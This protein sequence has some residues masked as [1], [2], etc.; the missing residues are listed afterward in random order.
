MYILDQ[1]QKHYSK[2][3]SHILSYIYPLER[4]TK[5]PFDMFPT[6]QTKNHKTLLGMSQ[7]F[8]FYCNMD[9]TSYLSISFCLFH[10]QSWFFRGGQSGQCPPGKKKS[11]I[12]TSNQMAPLIS[13]QNPSKDKKNF[14][15]L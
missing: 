5:Y 12:F 1:D 3:F 14:E 2:Q 10:T 6:K 13:N 7:S 9:Q 11:R 8:K 4:K 15:P